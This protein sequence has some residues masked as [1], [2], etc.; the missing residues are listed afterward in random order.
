[1]VVVVEPS[2]SASAGVGSTVADEVAVVDVASVA[3]DAVEPSFAEPD[4]VAFVVPDSAPLRPVVVAAVSG[5]VVVSPSALVFASSTPS[6]PADAFDSMVAPSPLGAAD[7]SAVAFASAVEFGARADTFVPAADALLRFSNGAAL[8]FAEPFSADGTESVTFPA[9]A[10]S[11]PGDV[12][13]L[14]VAAFVPFAAGAAVDFT[15]VADCEGALVPSRLSSETYSSR[16]VTLRNCASWTVAFTTVAFTSVDPLTFASLTL[17]SATVLP[18]TEP[19]E[20]VALRSSE[21]CT[22]ARQTVD[23]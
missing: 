23:A 12:V 11:F 19:F 17:L 4:G 7:P 15:V 1:M 18:S 13:A 2:F 22:E 20:R 6:A 16:T 9:D 3:F 8:A 14:S 5:P 10:V 21:S